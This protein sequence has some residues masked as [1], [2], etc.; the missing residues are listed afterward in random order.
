MIKNIKSEE[1]SVVLLVLMILM[2]I[3]IF[4]IS[5]LNT[6]DTELLVSQNSRCYKQNLYRAEG[7]VMET[8]RIL[9][10]EPTANLQPDSVTAPDWLMDG[11]VP[12]PSF[13]PE[14]YTTPWEPGTN[15]A[16]SPLYGNDNN[17][18]YTVVYEGVAAGSSLVMG[19]SQNWQY[20]VYGKSQLCR[21]ETGVVAG[22]RVRY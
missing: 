3:T 13:D 18:Q 10:A 19:A 12:N 8:S 4:G 7:I 1:G 20:S 14:D 16:T 5:S 15:S 17:A 22:Y 9:N 2:L 21:G 6:A 11:T